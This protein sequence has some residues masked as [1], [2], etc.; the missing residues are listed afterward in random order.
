M[1]KL[2][3]VF[4]ATQKDSE[5]QLLVYDSIGEGWFGGGVTAKDVKA[6]LDEAGDGI[7]TISVRLNSPGGDVFEGAAIYS[8][9]AQ[10]KAK[11][12]GYVDGIVASAAFTIAMACDEL[13]MSEAG[14]M[15]CHNAWGLCQ[16]D[17]KD[18]RKSADILDK[19][20]GVMCSIYAARSGMSSD[21][22]QA[23]M[24]AET[25]MNPQE[26]VDYG[27]ADDVIKK[28]EG[29]I[30]EEAQALASEF[31][32]I[33]KAHSVE[34]IKQVV[35]ELVA[36]IRDEKETKRVNGENLSKDVF[37]YSPDDK[38]ENW[39]LPIRFSAEA[40]TKAN[41]RNAV[42]EWSSTDMPDAV[43]KSKARDR[44]K[45]AAKKHGIE[46]SE[47]DLKIAVKANAECECTCPECEAGDCAD[48]SNPDC[49]DPN[50]DHDDEGKEMQAR[51]KHEIESSRF[52][53]D[54]A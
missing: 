2:K 15:M 50:C 19:I 36:N 7:K 6:K 12:I 18:M 17:G 31:R 8:L 45:A 49:E 16:G 10:H 27:F 39:K 34:E 53:F 25:W 46:L 41:I 40:K 9:L 32:S 28:R 43:E 14:E 48:C 5:L 4:A 42:T 37:A 23:L 26:A 3:R 1:S 29:K 35:T 33:I 38:K 54:L 47:D 30:E 24:D 22:C 13:H 11:V 51:F 44:I 52:Q 20:S 21:D